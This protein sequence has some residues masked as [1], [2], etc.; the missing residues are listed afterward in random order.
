M[1]CCSSSIISCEK[2]TQF[3]DIIDDDDDDDNDEEI[4][5]RALTHLSVP[6]ISL[7]GGPGVNKTILGKRLADE[8]GFSEIIS[9]ELVRMEVSNDTERG[10]QFKRI[11][12]EGHNLPDRIIFKIIQRKMLSFVNSRGFIIVGYPRTKIQAKL[13]NSQIRQP[14]LMFYV[15][16]G[17]QFIEERIKGRAIAN[18]RFDD[19]VDAINIRVKTFFRNIDGILRVNKNCVTVIDGQREINEIFHACRDAVNS[20]LIKYQTK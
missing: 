5:S 1:G 15:W 4:D 8:F 18:E 6:I 17:K 10:R 11:M 16:A 19:T 7:I 9:S 14:D 2:L 20:M 12:L 3:N 13:F